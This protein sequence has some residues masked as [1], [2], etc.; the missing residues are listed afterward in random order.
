MKQARRDFRVAIRPQRQAIKRARRQ[1]KR[2]YNEA[3]D[4]VQQVTGAL[5]GQL[6]QIPGAYAAQTSGIIPN[7]TESIGGLNSML[8]S[9][10][11]VVPGAERA[12]GVANV[13]A[14][15]S[16]AIEQIAGQQ[17]NM[18]DYLASGAQQGAVQG[19][20][21]SRNYLKDYQDFL[22]DN[23]QQMVD[24][25]AQAHDA[26]LQRLDQLKQE[27][28]DRSMALKAMGM[29][30]AQIDQANRQLDAE[31]WYMQQQ[32]QRAL[33][34][35]RRKGNKDKGKAAA[36]APTS[37]GIGAM[38]GT[39]G[40]G[41]GG[42]G[43]GMGPQLDLTEALLPQNAG[44]GVVARWVDSQPMR[45]IAENRAV[46]QQLAAWLAKWAQ[47]TIGSD[48]RIILPPTRGFN[49]P[50]EVQQIVMMFNQKVGGGNA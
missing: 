21:T 44:P 29:Q 8:G 39:S 41:V 17:Q 42:Q 10:I 37:G 7:V 20:V 31:I 45:N 9:G 6:G 49:L 33:R 18:A 32:A 35:S 28:F 16:G 26:I 43:Q 14:I 36:T 22:K 24:L 19:A 27:R 1:G 12:A 38:P 3:Q 48:G 23:R 4:R 13:G 50:P 47:V 5:L 11:G 25:H 30:Q 2:D 15:G 34:G 46:A 40:G